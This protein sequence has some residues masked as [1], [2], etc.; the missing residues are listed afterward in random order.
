MMTGLQNCLRTGPTGTTGNDRASSGVPIRYLRRTKGMRRTRVYTHSL[1]FI[2]LTVNVNAHVAFGLCLSSTGPKPLFQNNVIMLTNSNF[3]SGYEVWKWVFYLLDASKDE[4]LSLIN[5]TRR[6]KFALRDR[7][8]DN[9]N[10]FLILVCTN[11]E[12]WQ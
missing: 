9:F 3:N 1:N 8:K 6:L 12:V 11:K 10:F 7:L 4:L 5:L 2:I